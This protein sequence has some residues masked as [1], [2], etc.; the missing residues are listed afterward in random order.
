M[1]WMDRINWVAAFKTNG[2]KPRIFP[3]DNTETEFSGPESVDIVH[4]VESRVRQLEESASAQTT[5]LKERSQSIEYL[6]NLR[7]TH[8][9]SK[10][11]LQLEIE[12]L[13]SIVKNLDVQLQ[14]T[15]NYI[16]WLNQEK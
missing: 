7:A 14:R 9:F 11:K 12:K 5:A 8:R 3:R 6:I 15:R 4:I 2:L 1:E 16:K 10:V 13:F